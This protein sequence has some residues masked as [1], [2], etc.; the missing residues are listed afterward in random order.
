MALITCCTAVSA[1][2][3]DTSA[4]GDNNYIVT[5]SMWDIDFNTSTITSDPSAIDVRFG[6]ENGTNYA[7]GSDWVG[8]HRG[9]LAS[10]IEL[11]A[12]PDALNK[13]NG[14]SVC[15][16]T[17]N[18]SDTVQFNNLLTSTGNTKMIEYVFDVCSND[19]ST[20]IAAEPVYYKNSP[21]TA[22][23]NWA[24][25]FKIDKSGNM[26]FG[27][28]TM[29]ASANTWYTV[30]ICM[31]FTGAMQYCY[32]DDV[33]LGT[34]PF[35]ADGTAY[36]M[37]KLSLVSK[38]GAGVVWFDNVKVSEMEKLPSIESATTG[39][40][41]I[42]LTFSEEIGKDNFEKDGKL[43][44]ISA[45]F[46]NNPIQFIECIESADDPCTMRFVS[47]SKILTGVTLDVG[48]VYMGATLRYSL[49][50]DP[51][52]A[53]I[54]DVMVTESDGFYSAE[55]YCCNSTSE[56]VTA[57][58]MIALYNEADELVA[59]GCSGQTNLG[60][61]PMITASAYSQ[62]ASYAEVFFIKDWTSMNAFKN[63]IYSTK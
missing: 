26:T 24:T 23:R 38:G 11:K 16:T 3:G 37:H 33:L 61:A 18:S 5:K 6:N 31:D 41:Y 56:E 25:I 21:S 58:M 53:D 27:S 32:V 42:E 40:D 46:M 63:V 35:N 43:I 15:F 9:S 36:G 7:N 39:E 20:N 1:A 54:Y 12:N 59:V 50:V 45:S 2:V 8:A 57:I 44:N 55:G 14:I 52:A 34:A 4:I 30:R 47:S 10:T 60:F 28:G 22:N 13:D 49:K 48:V 29:S 51:A 17:A 19:F 62:T